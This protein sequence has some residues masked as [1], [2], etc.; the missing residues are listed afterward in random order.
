M[1]DVRVSQ[2]DISSIDDLVILFDGYR[3]FY[4]RESAVDS[5][6]TFLSARINNKESVIFI[7]YLDNKPAGFTQLY[8]SFS[9][10]SLSRTFILN[11]LYVAPDARRNAVASKLMNA[12]K[13]Y[14]KS[15]GAI[16][17]TLSTE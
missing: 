8:P 1:G 15:V 7:A 11:D 5:A 6:R 10:L 3:Q 16:K 2:A 9:S 14:V 13:E 17:L 4:N 12:A